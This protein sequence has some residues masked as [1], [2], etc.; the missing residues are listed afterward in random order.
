MKSSS[1]PPKRKGS[2]IP[3]EYV[4]LENREIF[5]FVPSGSEEPDV[6]RIA[7]LAQ[8]LASMIW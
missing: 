3:A 7:A 6:E 4:F 5:L 8:I 2:M 1:Y